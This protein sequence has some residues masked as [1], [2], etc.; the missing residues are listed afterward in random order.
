M[1]IIVLNHETENIDILH[2]TDEYEKWCAQNAHRYDEDDP[3]NTC[4]SECFNDF[5]TE[6]FRQLGYDK[7]EFVNYM[8]VADD[9]PVHLMEIYPDEHIIDYLRY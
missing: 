3:G 8:R 5:I 6:L 9:T 1:K 7:P 4:Y 2:I